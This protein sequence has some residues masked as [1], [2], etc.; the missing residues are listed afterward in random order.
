MPGNY[1][2]DTPGGIL[3]MP[4]VHSFHVTPALPESLSALRTL[5]YNIRWA[6][7]IETSELFQRLDRDLWERTEHNP[8]RMLGTIS[9]Q[10][11]QDTTLDES[12]L[13]HMDRAARG[14]ES[15]L[16]SNNTWYKRTYGD[17][18]Q[19]D[20]RIA[21]FSMEFGLTE[22][23]PIYS[24][25]LGV[26]AGDHLKSSSDLGLPLV[27]VGL[28]YQQGYFRQR[29]NADGWQQERYPENDFYNLP[30][31]PVLGPDGE[32]IRIQVE[33]PGRPVYAQL[34]RVEVGRIPLYLLDTNIS[35]NNAADQ[36]ITDTLYGGDTEMRLKQELI[37]GIGGLRALTALGISPTVCHMNEGHAA[38][39]ALERVRVLRKTQPIDYWE[40]Q[41]A[42]AAGNLFT[43]HTPV[44][45]GFDVF[46]ADLLH[47]Y[48]DPMLP[49]LGLSF[50]EFLGLGRVRS[51]D[52]AEQF[53]MAVL[54]LRHAHHVNAVSELH[55]KVTRR[56][57]QSMY[58]GFPEEEVPID[59]VTN[60][61]HIRSFISPEMSD[62]LDH[63]LE[64]RWSQNVADP[65]VW[66]RIDKIPDDDLWRVR[67]R[68]RELLVNFARSRLK[69]QY[70]Q[71]NMSE[72][73]IRQTR[74]VLNPDALTIGFARR[75]ATYKRATLLLSDPARLVK[76]LTDPH[77]PVQILLAGKAH[78]RDDGGKE[79]IRQIVQF[80]RHDEVRKSIVFLEDYDIGLAR[81]LV[82]GVDVWLNTPRML[83]E[84]SGTSGMKV[85][86]NGG[87][88]L[89]I[90]DGWWAEGYDPSA[91]WSI[92]KG[93]EY[94]DP[95]YQDRM[96]ALALYELLEKE[97]VP[98]FYDRNT[99]GLPRAWIERVKSSMK[100]LCPVYNTNRM[101]SEYAQ[102]FYFP[103][104]E[105][106]K[107]LGQNELEHTK[108]LV[109][110]KRRM[111]EGWHQVKVE[112]VET[113]DPAV[114]GNPGADNG[115]SPLCVGDNLRVTAFVRLG[116]L[117]PADVT[118]Q[119]VHGVL[120]SN[121]QIT[122]PAA[123]PL[124]WKSA[125][126][127]LNRYEGSL[128]CNRSGLQGFA[129]RVLPA[130]EDAVL[131]QELSL[132]TWE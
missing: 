10:R 82:Q 15:Y 98:L 51:F 3:Y 45:A 93:E 67:Q 101:V 57:V 24:G 81:Q 94:A 83:M 25:G 32:P 47:R 108:E 112:R 115:L 17:S 13:A 38:F 109:A 41:E 104:V 79:L 91:G 88:N 116:Q 6:W 20:M 4:T 105:R 130:H 54:A 103:M 53:N 23:L 77:R 95:D 119:V 14:L 50:D 111:G 9:Q 124:E 31:M 127:G 97:V 113:S 102:K 40:G 55:G 72:Y 84:A 89:S 71:R 66:E 33:F 65:S 128:P 73:E 27:G 74:E 36:N 106:Y 26:L 132:I 114:A 107:R 76:L 68:R 21:Y 120:D 60:G 131:P 29:L 46:T 22:C 59:S 63:Y 87:L 99:E 1:A 12:F 42:T 69:K 48:F 16:K 92:G 75:F 43:T 121:R 49:E 126:D 96:E 7:D 2:E 11:L 19:P 8:V 62:L 80:A 44:P 61:I 86:P 110:W 39:L 125:A 85:L 70:E 18:V 129:V 122:Q 78:P 100:I 118:V 64:G 56:M 30:V 28:L 123:Q 34:W 5:A 58:P 37:L 90:P 35:V 52:K 117:T